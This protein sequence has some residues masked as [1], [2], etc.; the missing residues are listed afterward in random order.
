MNLRKILLTTVTA[1]AA[2]CLWAPSAQAEVFLS[3]EDG[4][5]ENGAEIIAT[6][7]N[8]VFTRPG[9][10][11]FACT[12]IDL[13]LR[14]IEDGTEHLELEQLGSFTT[15]GCE[16]NQPNRAVTTDDGTIG[17]GEGNV[18]T[19]DTSGTAETSTLFTWTT[20]VGAFTH[21]SHN[22]IV[23][24]TCPFVGTIHFAPKEET[25]DELKAESSIFSF[26]CG[27]AA[28]HADFTLKT[29]NGDSVIIHHGEEDPPT[30]EVW[31]SDGESGILGTEAGSQ[32]RARI[33]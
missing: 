29:A 1:L 2:I 7:Q 28:M 17:V 21:E 19:I 20:Y 33:S 14:L 26:L 4:V 8:A 25:G 12:S 31:L 16:L 24:A 9:G 27:E 11:F 5:L 6:S 23:A 22:G 30:P 18:I 13:H 3:D 15:N 32:R 10:T